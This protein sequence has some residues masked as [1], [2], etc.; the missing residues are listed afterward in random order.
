M[1]GRAKNCPHGASSELFNIISCHEG[2]YYDNFPCI[3]EDIENITIDDSWEQFLQNR[4]DFSQ[5]QKIM[6][7]LQITCNLHSFCRNWNP[8]IIKLINFDSAKAG[9]FIVH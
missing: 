7:L 5:T 4:V 9:I 6:N 2:S 1:P 8:I 3:C